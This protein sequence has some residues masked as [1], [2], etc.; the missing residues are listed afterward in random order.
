[1]SH[2]MTQKAKGI[3]EKKGKTDSE[4]LKLLCNGHIRKVKTVH[5][6]EENICKSDK[7][8]VFGIYKKHH[9]TI[10]NK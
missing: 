1:M 3:K 8:F 9:S 4:N 2:A 6:T 5:R 7:R 10:K